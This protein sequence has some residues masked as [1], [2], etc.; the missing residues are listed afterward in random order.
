MQEEQTLNSVVTHVGINTTRRIEGI[1]RF[2][3][4]AVKNT[5][6]I[7]KENIVLLSVPQTK[8]KKK[9]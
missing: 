6:I 5:G 4:I 2:V 1:N 7:I 3:I 8:R 9:D